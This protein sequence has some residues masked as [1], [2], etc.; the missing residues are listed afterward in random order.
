VDRDAARDE[1]A[2]TA[3]GGTAP[4][5]DGGRVLVGALRTPHRLH[6]ADAVVRVQVF[7]PVRQ[8][9][10]QSTR[11]IAQQ[12]V[13]TRRKIQIVGDQAPVPRTVVRRPH[14]EFEERLAIPP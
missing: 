6:D 7:D 8:A 12:F 10:G 1:P 13:A 5:F 9:G 14:G 11:G 4:E 2:V 3:S